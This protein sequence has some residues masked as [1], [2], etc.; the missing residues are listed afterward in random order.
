M[1][2]NPNVS[3]GFIRSI[4]FL[5]QIVKLTNQ[6]CTRDAPG[7][8]PL[9][10]YD[11]QGTYVSGNGAL[12]ENFIISPTGVVAKST[13]FVFVKFNDAV[14]PEWLYFDEIDLPALASQSATAKPSGYPLR[15]S[16]TELLYQIPPRVGTT[17][18]PPGMRLNGS[19]R[20]YQI[21]VALGTA[22]GSA[23]LHIWIKGGE[24]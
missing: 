23:P 5:G 24:Y 19:S 4:G 13:L 7:N 18:Y 22:I 9:V 16:V 8:V 21:G 17:Q 3:P 11:S 12:I 20:N 2:E 1:P 6:V 14:A 15:A 10:I